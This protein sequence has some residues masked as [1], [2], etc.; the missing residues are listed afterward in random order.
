MLRLESAS[1]LGRR[2]EGRK[3]AGIQHAGLPKL[4]GAITPPA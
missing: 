3:F 2:N 4:D 1:V